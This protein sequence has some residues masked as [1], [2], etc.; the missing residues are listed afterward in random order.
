MTLENL[1]FALGERTGA[2]IDNLDR[3]EKLG[4][5]PSSDDWIAMRKL[6][7]KMVYEYIEDPIT[8]ADALQAGNDYVPIL[9][10]VVAYFLA[11][12]QARGWTA[13]D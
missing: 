2:A 1:F 7:N 9:S 5:I 6:R 8:L 13:S 12:M 4:W 11:D 3:A 10:K